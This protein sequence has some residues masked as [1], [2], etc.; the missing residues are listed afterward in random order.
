MVVFKSRKVKKVKKQRKNKTIHT[1]YKHHRRM[2]KQPKHKSYNA[3]QSYYN[4]N[5]KLGGLGGPQYSAPV[6]HTDLQHAAGILENITTALYLGP[7]INEV[8]IR[9]LDNLYDAYN[10]IHT[11]EERR[12]FIRIFDRRFRENYN[13]NFNLTEYKYWFNEIITRIENRE[14]DRVAELPDIGQKNLL[15]S[16]IAYS[17]YLIGE[18]Q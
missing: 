4:V 17:K 12:E 8:M 9:Y 7:A 14:N 13:L 3:T 15:L 10:Y 11:Y 18:T 2:L 6:Y 16:Q 1:K 5:N